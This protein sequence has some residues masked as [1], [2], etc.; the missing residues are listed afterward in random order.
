MSGPSAGLGCRPSSP[1]EPSELRDQEPL[2]PIADVRLGALP[3]AAT[4]GGRTSSASI[5]AAT[6]EGR[7]RPSI[8]R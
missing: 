5:Q 4:L 6:S 2:G 1:P 8:T 7:V 3:V